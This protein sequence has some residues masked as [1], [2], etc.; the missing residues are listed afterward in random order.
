LTAQRSELA[1]TISELSSE[2]E[3]IGRAVDTARQ[4]ADE[5]SASL[6]A[7]RS[8]L[9]AL[10]EQR[11]SMD[12]EAETAPALTGIEPG[13][14]EAGPV[15][16]EFGPDGAGDAGAA[17][18]RR[19]LSRRRP[20]HPG[21]QDQAGDTVTVRDVEG[22][23]VCELVAAGSDGRVDTGRLLG[24]PANAD[25]AG[26]RSL[27]GEPG[28]DAAATR[29]AW[30]AADRSRVGAC[31]ALSS[32]RLARRLDGRS[33]SPADGILVVGVPGRRHG[34]RPAG[35]GHAPRSAGPAGGSPP[36]RRAY[37]AR[38]AGRSAHRSA[39]RPDD[40]AGLCR[41]GRRVHPG[42]RRGRAASAPTFSASPP[43]SSTRARNWRSIRPSPARCSAAATPCPACRRRPSTATW[44]RW[45]RS[46]ATPAAGTTLL[47]P[48]A[49]RAT[50][51][52][53]AIPAM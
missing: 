19:A 7:A 42:D 3:Q 40:G 41:A 20:R 48:P 6:D 28:E 53:R 38:A 52:T 39:R 51:T 24:M 15:I 22:G 31:P 27:L 26:L 36:P 18:G 29:R 10:Q 4:E 43:A 16:A 14:Y 9:A 2:R 37:A 12:Q 17:A 47:P 49:I 50:T 33:S 32:A 34:F 44:S 13:R 8:E 1:Q 25:A 5:L 30:S 23:Q 11:E 35:H 21:G 45:S 46:S